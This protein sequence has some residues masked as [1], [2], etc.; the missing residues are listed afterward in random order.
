MSYNHSDILSNSPYYDDFDD[1]K[2]FL[3]ILFKPGYSVQAREL[4]QL[5]TLL[6]NQVSKLGSHI[7]KNGSLVFGGNSTLTNCKFLRIKR[8]NS[9]LDHTTLRNKIISDGN[10]TGAALARILYTSD[11]QTG[12]N[13]IILFLQYLT[14]SEFS[15]STT[16]FFEI[17]KSEQNANVYTPLPFTAKPSS[18]G[19]IPTT[20]DATLI[21]VENG[22]FY[23]D[24]FF[25]NN[26][27]QTVSLFKLTNGYRDFSSPTNRVGFTLNR[28]TIN[29]VEDETL[30]DPAN[31]SYNYNAPGADRYKINLE[32]TSYTFDNLET[33]PEEY[34]TE[35]FI[36]LARTVNGTL[37]FIRRIPTYSDLLEIFARRTYDESGSYTVKPFGLEIKNHNR[38]DKYT[39]T[40]G[41]YI[42]NI[43]SSPDTKSPFQYSNATDFD[44]LPPFAGDVLK[45][46]DTAGNSSFL[47]IVSSTP[48][49]N[50]VVQLTVSYQQTSTND[51]VQIVNGTKFYLYRKGSPNPIVNRFLAAESTIVVDQDQNGKYLISETPRGSEDKFLLSVQPGKAYVFGY[52]FETI[53][54]TNISV[55][56]P[57][58]TVFLDNYEVNTN[59]GNYFIATPTLNSSSLYEFDSYSNNLNI[60]DFPEVDLRGQFVEINIPKVEETTT[61]LPV[62]YWSPL[63]AKEHSNKYDSILFLNPPVGSIYALDKEITD[64]N[65]NGLIRPTET[66][67]ELKKKIGQQITASSSISYT[68]DYASFE[69]ETNISRL[70]FTEP[71]HGDFRTAYGSDGDPDVD[72]RFDTDEYRDSNLN[73]VYQIDYKDISSNIDDVPLLNDLK[74]RLLIKRVKSRRWVP[75]GRTGT[76]SGS[77]LYVETGTSTKV[78]GNNGAIVNLGMTLPGTNNDVTT[79]QEAGVVFNPEVGS[80]ISYGSSIQSVI[81]QNNVVKIVLKERTST[82]DCQETE[83]GSAT[84]GQGKFRIGDV[85]FQTYVP[86]STGVRK[87]ANGLVIAV[88]ESDVPNSY[89]IYVEIQGDEDFVEYEAESADY[90]DIGLLYGPCACYTIHDVLSLDNSTCGFFTRIKFRESGSYGDFTEGQTVYQFNIDYTP[91]DDAGTNFDADQCVSKGR[92]IS[93]DLNSRTLI[94][95]TTNNQF[96]KKSGWVFEIGSGIRY[97]GRGWDL[98]KHTVSF[99]SANGVNEIET[100][101]GVFVHIDQEYISG[102]DFDENNIFGNAKQIIESSEQNYNSSKRLFVGDTLTQNNSG[103]VSAGRVVYF[104]AGDVQNPASTVEE[105]TTTILLAKP[106]IQQF[107]SYPFSFNIGNSTSPLLRVIGKTFTYSVTSATPVGNGINNTVIG[108]AKIRQL[109]RISN[110]QYSVHLFDIRM[111]TIGSTESKYTLNSTTNIAEVDGSNIFTIETTNNVSTIQAPQQNTLLFDLPVGDTINNVSDIKYRLQRDI[112]VTIDNTP[113]K[114]IQSDTP[115][116]IRFIGGATGTGEEVGKVDVADL[117]EHYIFVNSTTGVIYDLSDKTYF[118]KIITNVADEASTSTL[119]MYLR[120]SDGTNVLP[121]GD[122][123]LIATMSVGGSTEVGIRRKTKKRGVK[124]LSFDS[125]ELVIPVADI[126]SIDS[127]TTTSGSIYNLS[128]FD[129]NNGQTDNIYEWATLKLKPE[130]S[131]VYNLDEVLVSYTYFEHVGNGPIVVNSYETQNDIPIYT[132]PS[133]N[134]KYALDTLIDFR[135]YR[136]STGDLGGIYGIPVITESFSVDYSYYQAKN[137]KLVLTRDRQFKVIESPSSLTP[138]IP[139]DEPNAMTLFTIESPAYLRDVN[140]LKITPYNHQRYTMNDIRHLEKRIENLEYFTK[141][142]LLE[143]TAEGAIISDNDGNALIKTSILVDGFSG[144]GIGDTENPDYNC[145]VDPVNNVLRPSFKT[146]SFEFVLDSENSTIQTNNNTGLITLDFTETPLVVQTLSSST[147]KLNTFGNS[148]WLGNMRITPSS[149]SWFDTVNKPLL[150]T[151]IDGENDNFKFINSGVKNNNIGSFGTKWNNWQTNWQGTPLEEV[152]ET[153]TK[154]GI[155]N[156]SRDIKSRTPEIGKTKIGDKVLD[157]DI[158]PFMRN[159]NITVTVTGLKPNTLIYPYFDS[160]R[161]DSYCTTL[162]GSVFVNGTNNRTNAYGNISFIFNLPTGKFRVGEKLLSVMDNTSGIRNFASTIAEAKYVSSGINSFK[163]NYFISSRPETVNTIDRK[164]SFVAQTFFVDSARYPQGVFVKS[165]D[166]FFASKDQQGIPVKLEIRPVASGFPSIGEGSITYPYATKILLPND[167][168]LVTSGDTPT[169][170]SLDGTILSNAT[171]FDFD[172]PVHLLPGEHSI[173]LSSNS[174]DYSVY[175]AEIGQNQINTE[176]PISEQPYSGKMFKTNNN[177]LWSELQTTDLMFVVNRCVFENSG[178]LI[179]K[180]PLILGREKQNYSIA[181]LNMSY[182]DF[183]G[184][185]TSTVLETLDENSSTRSVSSIKPNTNV[186]YG[187]TKKVIYDGNSLRLIV[188][189]SSDGILSPVIDIEKLNLLGIRNL[190]TAQSSQT[191]ELLPL[192]IS[193][194]VRYITKTVTLEPGLEATNCSVF[195]KAYKPQGTSIDVFIK[196]QTQGSDSAFL[197]ENYEILTPDSTTVVSTSESDYKEIKYSLTQEQINQ[198]FGKFAI[199]IVLYSSNEAVVPNVKDLRIITA[200]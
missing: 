136:D 113:T 107:S 199:K 108:K 50:G 119:T 75:A 198:E 188:N 176:I 39:F 145:S 190:I 103:I 182:I 59:V 17:T 175:V 116:N 141:L 112:S 61:D 180:D 91:I 43:V 45:I 155:R 37:D 82:T 34:S 38:N 150:L 9:S 11:V 40:A 94:V 67:D 10:T 130:Y 69:T 48:G 32:L 195:L 19:S 64:S 90:S 189:M 22:I 78:F 66:D 92:V 47:D 30:K 131:T 200:V 44:N 185:I 52:E 170:G 125:G 86:S 142:N 23:V 62:K 109:H 117:L 58:D 179:M 5:Q 177:S 88:T 178:S 151:N 147:T 16:T 35:D 118:T 146:N 20:G 87:Q 124:R 123:R 81:Q 187:I 128:F 8:D 68:I 97:G 12:D 89:T 29:A 24:G 76:T 98:N 122:Y 63:Y 156:I 1:T 70:V 106:L 143:K 132:S 3:R 93:W 96:N 172:A 191:E 80:D 133:T 193:P 134:R 4:T 65:I 121:A 192:A 18:E 197:N 111:N 104:K 127:L 56:K 184:L 126:V 181:N 100:S 183:G 166:L 110:D 157:T 73:Y 41:Y 57:R 167:V 171:R 25:V 79:P 161:I 153:V 26:D 163:N 27:S 77:T 154:N 162:S 55:N 137:Y 138:V 54:N 196:R 152:K 102:R 101:T 135:P 21:S 169:P 186:N 49:L 7:F 148:V 120:Q 115:A 6:Q 31:G 74:D 168:T 60:N 72:D 140:D 105:S 139:S 85:V 14:G 71:Y 194:K 42:G 15:P 13:Y 165:I 46:Y 99:V 144:H 164:Q 160:I 159:K 28:T 114:V 53:N 149:D 2:N 158:V 174:P 83:G 129:F 33:K 84:A 51:F 95:L 36:E 173:V